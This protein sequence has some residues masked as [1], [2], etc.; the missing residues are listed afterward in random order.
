MSFSKKILYETLRSIN[1]ATF[2]GSYQALGTPLDN[3][4]TIVKIVNNSSVLVTVSVDGVN[5][6]DICPLGS[7]F[8]YDVT[9]N[10]VS[11]DQ[12]GSIFVPRRTQYYVK[13]SASTGFVY[14]V[15]QYIQQV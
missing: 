10:S 13:G 15:A 5:D 11:D 7:F 12:S 8:L 4:C 1:S 3:P 6:H 2:T 9:G 14:L